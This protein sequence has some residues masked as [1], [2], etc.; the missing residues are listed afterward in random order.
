MEW[1]RIVISITTF[2]LVYRRIQCAGLGGL[3]HNTIVIGWPYGW[4][5]ETS[6]RNYQ[7]FIGNLTQMITLYPAFIGIFTQ[8][9]TV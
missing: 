4:R 5:A 3:K 9:I 6:N 8:M 7:A 1:N 2:N